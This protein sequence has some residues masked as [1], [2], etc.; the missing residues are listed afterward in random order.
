MTGAPADR[1]MDDGGV[2]GFAGPGRN[3]GPEAGL[4]RRLHRRPGFA[5]GSGLVGLDQDR[6]AGAVTGR[7][8]DALGAGDQEIVADHL[9]PLADGPG[10]AHHAFLVAF[11]QRVL[12]GDDGVAFDPVDQEPRQAVGVHLLAVAGE[13]VFPLGAELGRRHVERDRH[14]PARG[15]PRRLDGAGQHVQGVLVVVERRPQAAFVGDALEQP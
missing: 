10:E 13:F 4:N 14:V 8:A 7:L 2:L 3:N 15:K 12:D 11:G 6:V 5:Q 1:Q 9:H